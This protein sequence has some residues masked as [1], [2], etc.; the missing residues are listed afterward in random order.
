MTRYT[1][2]LCVFAVREDWLAHASIENMPE[3][4]QSA[5]K[6]R[7]NSLRRVQCH[8]CEGLDRA[9]NRRE[10]YSNVFTCSPGQFR[11]PDSSNVQHSVDSSALCHV[12]LFVL[13]HVWG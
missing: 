11:L 5:M 2:P 7:D 6:F 3:A 10:T 4:L 12:L 8:A 1:E 9:V 13:R